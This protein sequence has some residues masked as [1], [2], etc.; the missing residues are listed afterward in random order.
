MN[1]TS[2]VLLLLPGA[3]FPLSSAC[4]AYGVPAV[5]RTPAR[6]TATCVARQVSP[7]RLS[8]IMR[9]GCDSQPEAAA[10]LARKATDGKTRR[11]ARRA[12]KRHLADRIIRRMW[13]DEIG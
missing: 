7:T 13:R 6:P 12:H 9:R 10:Y 4:P 5:V 1:A 2:I 8:H 3:G 11:E